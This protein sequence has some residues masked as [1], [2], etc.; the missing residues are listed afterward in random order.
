MVEILTASQALDVNTFIQANG[1]GSYWH[2]LQRISTGFI[3]KMPIEVLKCFELF[4]YPNCKL[5][6]QQINF[7]L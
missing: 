5:R 3:T 4:L 1:N 7:A 6:Q 2:G